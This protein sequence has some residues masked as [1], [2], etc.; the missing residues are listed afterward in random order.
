MVEEKRRTSAPAIDRPARF[1]SEVIKAGKYQRSLPISRE[2]GPTPVVE[3]CPLV[4]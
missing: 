4:K 2:F 1:C 3:L